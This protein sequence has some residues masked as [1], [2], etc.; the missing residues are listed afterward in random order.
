MSGIFELTGQIKSRG[1]AGELYRCTQGQFEFNAK[2]GIISKDKRLSRIL[3]V[4]NFT[5]IVKGKIPD[6][7]TQGFSYKTINVQGK[8]A[9]KKM[10][11]D[12]L[13]MDGKTLD[14]YGTGSFD[15]NQ[16]TLDVKLLAAPFQTVDSAIKSIP[17]VNYLL[18]GNLISIPVRISGNIDDPGV[19]IMSAK[20]MTSDF[21]NFA[22][23]IIKSPIKL[24]KN[25]NPYN[26]SKSK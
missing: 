14:L 3:E 11:F 26:K 5:E 12:K 22:D 13:F 16:N 18:A 4:V 17:G 21:L 6:L 15:F 7:K 1:P 19:N 8:F 10:V 24:I 9:D 25:L 23:R 2:D 20:D